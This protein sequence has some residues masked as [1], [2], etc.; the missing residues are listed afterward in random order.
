MKLP[1]DKKERAKILILIAIGAVLA[2]YGVGFLVVKPLLKGKT[3][4]SEQIAS[5][6][7]KLRRAGLAINRIES[8]KASISNSLTEL[9]VI[10]NQ[11][12][13]V[14]R[15]RLG[16]F[17]LGA[18]EIIDT[19]ARE[20]DISGQVVSENGISK[21]PQSTKRTAPPIFDTYTVTV[22]LEAGV[23][24]LLRML[25]SLE[26][27]NPY[28]CVSS[29]VIT[30]QPGK[31]GKHAVSFEVQW[32]IWADSKMPQRL[33]DQLKELANPGSTTSAVVRAAA[34]TKVG[35]KAVK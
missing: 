13:M 26:R 16:N 34:A 4:Q 20:A 18:T 25:Q 33:Q 3:E 29:L 9:D 30:G 5:L 27:S 11:K 6:Q 14:L 1:E 19:H 2:V 23:H 28:L 22:H 10:A 12:G 7:E 24:E 8:D 31:P 15:D 21:V 17:L 32:P 35:E